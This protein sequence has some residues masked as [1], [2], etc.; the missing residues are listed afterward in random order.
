MADQIQRQQQTFQQ[1][2]QESINSYMQ[3]LN[4]PPFYVPEQS[5]EGQQAFQQASQ[6]WMEQAQ[7]QQETFQQISQQWME[8]AQQQQQAFQQIV[9]Q[10]LSTYM[11]LFRPSR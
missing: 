7:Q 11:D 1:M 4:T 2:M 8:Q 5:Q 10:S 3:L 6:R 9:Q